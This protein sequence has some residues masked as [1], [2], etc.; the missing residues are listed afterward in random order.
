LLQRSPE[1]QPT[2]VKQLALSLSSNAFKKIAWRRV[3]TI[4]RH[5]FE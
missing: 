4:L 1:H 2:S 5:S 3:S